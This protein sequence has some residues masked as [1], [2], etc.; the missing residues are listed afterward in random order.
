MDCYSIISKQSK[1][2][3]CSFLA[4]RNPQTNIPHS[5]QRHNNPNIA[6]PTRTHIIHKITCLQAI[7][8]TQQWA[9]AYILSSH[10]ST[11]T[12]HQITALTQLTQQISTILSKTLSQTQE[13]NR[14]LAA[15]C[16]D[17]SY[18]WARSTCSAGSTT[19]PPSVLGLIVAVSAVVL[20]MQMKERWKGD[21]RVEAKE[22]YANVN[23]NGRSLRHCLSSREDRWRG[24]CVYG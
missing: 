22:K 1:K 5:G 19:M 3:V 9:R 24:V 23:G 15:I 8:Q 2:L 13:N 4:Y 6:T 18:E 7:Q 21:M 17:L 20:L 14:A 16:A 12:Y 11:N 10:K